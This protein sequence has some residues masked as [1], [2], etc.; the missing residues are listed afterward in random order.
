M[1]AATAA[2]AAFPGGWGGAVLTADLGTVRER[3]KILVLC[4][5]SNSGGGAGLASA[6]PANATRAELIRALGRHLKDEDGVRVASFGDRFLLSPDWVSGFS[7]IWRAFESVAQP[8]GERSPIW[9]AIYSSVDAFDGTAA[10]RIIFVVSDGK[11]SGN[12][13]GFEEAL[14]RTMK[15]NVAVY[16]ANVVGRRTR[17]LLAEQ[18]GHPAARLKKIA[19]AT[20]GA[21][22]ETVATK[23]L[24]TF[25]EN[26]LRRLRGS[27]STP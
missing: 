1:A 12:I 17:G 18:P 16:A 23:A 4:D 9:D 14:N 8:W 7:A 22:G 3:L 20:K 5:M 10:R 27:H 25:F 19:E 26:V 21:Y 24:P 13:H 11:A 6:G 15:G 2:L